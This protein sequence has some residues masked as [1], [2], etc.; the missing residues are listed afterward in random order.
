MPTLKETKKRIGSAKTVHKIT[1]AMK[2]ISA[3]KS[4]N[5]QNANFNSRP[6]SQGLYQTVNNLWQITNP[7]DHPLLRRNESNAT[8]HVVITTDKGLCGSLLDRLEDFMAK[9]EAFIGEEDEYVIVGRKGREILLHHGKKSAAVF[10]LGFSKTPFSLITPIAKLVKE[11]YLLG[12]FGKVIVYY[13]HFINNLKQIPST[14]MLLPTQTEQSLVKPKVRIP[15]KDVA[16]YEPDADTVLEKLLPRY[17]EIQLYQLVL[18]SVASEHAARML[19]MDAA[20]RNANEIIEDLTLTYNKI[21]Q[22]SITRELL[23][24]TATMTAL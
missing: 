16:I 1:K 4:R 14:K 7:D 12:R 23:E 3:S 20:S 21:R 10:E 2:L 5:A 19:A 6:Y 9:S 13:T 22:E 11:S 17:L 15:F 18:E 24:I 8:C